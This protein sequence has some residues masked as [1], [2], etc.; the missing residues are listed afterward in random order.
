MLLIEA[1][2]LRF[3]VSQRSGGVLAPPVSVVPTLSDTATN[4]R[5][6][7]AVLWCIYQLK[8][9]QIRDTSSLEVRSVL[10]KLS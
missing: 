4:E 5:R 8:C 10:T 1:N 3:P 6:K 2:L 9:Q 7:V